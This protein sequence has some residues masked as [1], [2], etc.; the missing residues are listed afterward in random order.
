M[1]AKLM[2]VIIGLDKVSALTIGSV[3][4]PE[5]AIL[6]ALKKMMDGAKAIIGAQISD[7]S[8]TTMMIWR[9]FGIMALQET[10]MVMIILQPNLMSI[11]IF[12][13]QLISLTPR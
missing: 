9:W 3:K 8:I 12:L 7:L 1:I 5:L 2:R 13:N 6:A 11:S 4:V 10:G